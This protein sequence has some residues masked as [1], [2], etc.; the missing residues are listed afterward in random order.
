MK[1]LKILHIVVPIRNENST[2][3]ICF[4][5][6][7][8]DLETILKRDIVTRIINPFPNRLSI[9]HKLVFISFEKIVDMA[10][11]QIKRNIPVSNV[12]FSIEIFPYHVN[13]TN[14]KPMIRVENMSIDR[15]IALSFQSQLRGIIANGRIKDRA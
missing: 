1:M 11:E 10:K 2:V 9:P 5:S 3:L 14:S 15:D 4:I 6:V 13:L 12:V 8:K 7:K